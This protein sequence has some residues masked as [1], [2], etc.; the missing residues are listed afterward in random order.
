M[1]RCWL[2]LE[3]NFFLPYGAIRALAAPRS[4]F[5][6]PCLRDLQCRRSYASDV[7]RR[8][9]RIHAPLMRHDIIQLPGMPRK[10]HGSTTRR[11]CLSQKSPQARPHDYAERL[12]KTFASRAGHEGRDYFSAPLP[13]VS[14]SSSSLAASNCGKSTRP[15]VA[16]SSHDNRPT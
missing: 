3:T 8:T 15:D 14:F 2:A 13:P 12:A 5:D 1:G 11:T 10:T 7:P 16:R 4:R 6:W 9:S